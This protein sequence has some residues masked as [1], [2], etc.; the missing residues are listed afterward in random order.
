MAL[1]Q[2]AH[3]NGEA[4][5]MTDLATYLDQS[6][7]L[8]KHLCPRQ[9]LGARIGMYAAELLELELPQTNKRLVAF[10]ETDGCFADGISV[11][12]GCWFGRRTLRLMDYGKVA[13]T[14][15]DTQTDRALRIWPN[16][17]ARSRAA[18]YAP[19]E[20]RRWHMYLAAYQVMPTAELLRAEE[21][22]LAISLAAI[23]SR[24]GVRVHC[25]QCGEEII[26]EREVRLGSQ[27][28]CRSCAGEHYYY[29][30][31]QADYIVDDSLSLV[32]PIPLVR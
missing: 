2:V 28:L 20:R 31:G 23:I 6:T 14:F 22:T 10:V 4:H 25:D 30:A 26:N 11:T 17:L 32:S 7:A 3:D 12:T 29:R 16:P 15:V 13:A 21:V 5:P 1:I 27:T 18:D 8:H 9:V 24:P 19:S